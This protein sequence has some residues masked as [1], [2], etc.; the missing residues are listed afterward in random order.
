MSLLRDIQN[1]AVDSSTDVATLL[2]KC[3]ILAARLGNTKFKEWV[4]FELNGYPS[5]EQLPI[6]RILNTK[7]FGTFCGSFGSGANNAPIPPS[8]LPKEFR[9][10]VTTSYLAAP[11]SSYVELLSNP[12]GNPVEQWPAD[13]IAHFGQNIYQ[14]MNCVSAWKTIP[15]NSIAALLDTIKTRILDFVLEIENEAPDAGEAPPNSPPIAQDKVTQIFNTYI[16]GN[17]QNVST[18]SSHVNQDSDIK[19]YQNDF[20][21]LYDFLKSK[22]VSR[23]DLIHLENA[24]QD[25]TQE[26]G[27]RTKGH[28]VQQWTTNMIKK[29]A[30]GVWDVTTE[31]ATDILSKAFTSYFGF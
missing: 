29:A 23:D 27:K 4:D 8:C 31:V 6:Y 24:V 1:S 30:S 21:S 7:S 22:G 16:S 13:L 14:N 26:H 18:G 15:R 12:D 20:T 2:R 11:I 17:V 28:R 9:E 25:D 19:I 5:K 3:K 10:Y